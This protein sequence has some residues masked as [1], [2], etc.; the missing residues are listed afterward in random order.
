MKILM[1]LKLTYLASVNT[2]DFFCSNL[3]LLQTYLAYSGKMKTVSAKLIQYFCTLDNLQLS[4]I[5]ALDLEVRFFARPKVLKNLL[6]KIVFSDYPL[7]EVLALDQFYESLLNSIAFVGDKE[8]IRETKRISNIANMDQQFINFIDILE[9][10]D[11]SS[12]EWLK[13]AQRQS[14]IKI[15][16]SSSGELIYN[17]LF[18]LYKINL[19]EYNGLLENN[20]SVHK[21][22]E[23]IVLVSSTVKYFEIFG[24]Y[25]IKNFRKRN[26]NKII[27]LITDCSIT[28]DFI[29]Y[30]NLLNLNLNEGGGA[31]DSLEFEYIIRKDKISIASSIERLERAYYFMQDRTSNL[32][33][34]D[35]DMNLTDLDLTFLENQ[36]IEDV[37]LVTMKQSS[38]WWGAYSAGFIL[39][40]YN[41]KSLDYLWN[42]SNFVK[43]ND[44]KAKHWGI[45]QIILYFVSNYFEQNKLLEIKNYSYF[46]MVPYLTTPQ[47]LVKKKLGLGRL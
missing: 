34:S 18:N 14:P 36:M 11:R 30:C 46:D 24:E 45:D 15:D 25:F 1:K 28:T 41:S 17:N 35:I 3:I 19:F 4:S 47:E 43:L 32:F 8:I 26:K 42:L 27:F 22:K 9:K 44:N 39:A 5:Y 13:D 6:Q 31:L 16:N 33:I 20:I 21:P 10:F 29:N 38:S 2:R 23:T 40:R 7:I 37:G 12:L